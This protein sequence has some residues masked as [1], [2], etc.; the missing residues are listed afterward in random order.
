VEKRPLIIDNAKLAAEKQQR[1]V[2]E[3][4]QENARVG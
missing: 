2:V 4:I 3:V 1:E